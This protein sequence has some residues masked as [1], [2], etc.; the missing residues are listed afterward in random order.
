MCCATPPVYSMSRG[1]MTVRTIA[2]VLPWPTIGGVELGTLRI[3]QSLPRDRFRHV[4]FCLRGAAMQ[5]RA[6]SAGFEVADYQPQQISYHNPLPF[7]RASSALA[8]QFRARSVDLVACSDL[9]AAYYAACGG[10]LA[11]VPV[12]CHVRC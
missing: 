5:D 3:A 2:H 11:R 7:L 1:R 6:R 10:R 12:V 9:L 4:F 8:R